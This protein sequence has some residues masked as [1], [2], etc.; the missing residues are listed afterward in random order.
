MNEFCQKVTSWIFIPS[1][2]KILSDAAERLGGN[3]VVMI[4]L[5]RF[6]ESPHYPGGFVDMK[7]TSRAAY[8][9]GY[10]G[11]F[12][13]IA[14]KLGIISERLYVGSRAMTLVSTE[15]EQW[16][17]IVMIRYDSFSDLLSII[18]HP[19]YLLRA[20]PHRQAAIANWRFIASQ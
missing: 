14:S 10:A 7:E 13:E 9:E 3:P 20:E 2:P 17:D 6:R 1:R 16:D 15:D 18:R 5:L 19:D 8:Y 12:Q 4:N 11:V